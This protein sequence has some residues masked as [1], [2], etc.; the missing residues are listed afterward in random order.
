[1]ENK[2]DKSLLS[3]DRSK[4]EEECDGHPQLAF[5]W[6]EHLANARVVAKNAK[7]RLKLV[8]ARLELSIRSNPG[9]YGIDK[10]TEST[11]QASVRVQDEYEVAQDQLIKAEYDVDVLEAFVWALV[12]RKGQL[13]NLVHLWGSQ[14]WS[15]PDTSPTRAQ[16]QQQRERTMRDLPVDVPNTKGK[17]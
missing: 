9:E 11:V 10:V 12:D 5:T 3:I 7:N 1:V 16:Q 15:R 4:L 14:Y 2:P 6:G 13:E 17:K 8:E